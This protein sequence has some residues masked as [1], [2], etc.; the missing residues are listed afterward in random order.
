MYVDQARFLEVAGL[1]FAFL[2]LKL[3]LVALAAF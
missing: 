2:S 1:G 3:G